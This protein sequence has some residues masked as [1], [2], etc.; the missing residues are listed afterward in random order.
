MPDLL[1]KQ[2]MYLVPKAARKGKMGE[3]RSQEHRF[4]IVDNFSSAAAEAA[5]VL[6]PQ[7]TTY[8]SRSPINNLILLILFVS[9]MDS[10]VR[11]L[12]HFYFILIDSST[13]FSSSILRKL[14]P[15]NIS[16]TSADSSCTALVCTS[17][18]PFE[19]TIGLRESLNR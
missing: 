9:A 4:R 12:Y 6:P 16:W 18:S 17:Y 5:E 13:Q 2:C 7:P 8:S 19:M 14:R 1:Q 11:L 15:T 10:T 3:M